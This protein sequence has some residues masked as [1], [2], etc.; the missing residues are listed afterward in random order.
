MTGNLT[1]SNANGPSNFAELNIGY[2][3]SGETRAIDID[4]SWSGNENKS[5][6]FTHGSSAANM[7]A[8]INVLYTG[9][10]SKIRWGRLYHGGDSSAYVMEL[11][12][13]SSTTA[14]LTA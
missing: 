12:S 4:G 5:I 14:N 7:V 1:L 6:S 10:S 13:T 11:L 3:G 8:Q 9:S 2:A